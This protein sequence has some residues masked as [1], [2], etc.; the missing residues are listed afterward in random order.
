MKKMLKFFS[1]AA[2]SPVGPWTD[3]VWSTLP[4]LRTPRELHILSPLNRNPKIFRK[5]MKLL[6]ATLL[7]VLASGIIASEVYD[8]GFYLDLDGRRRPRPPKGCKGPK[9]NS[10]GRPSRPTVAPK[11]TL[12]PTRPSKKAPPKKA[13]K[14]SRTKKS[15]IWLK[16]LNFRTR[17]I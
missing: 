10:G 1:S 8:G 4:W 12:R 3:T 14:G 7:G 16:I 11:K 17:E 9:C 2:G 6:S 13:P 15:L 5:K